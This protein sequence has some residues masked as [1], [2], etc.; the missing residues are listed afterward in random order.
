MTEDWQYTT[1]QRFWSVD[2]ILAVPHRLTSFICVSS[3]KAICFPG[4]PP[5]LLRQE[6]HKFQQ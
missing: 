3:G 2:S 5:S 4:S 1:A 6:W